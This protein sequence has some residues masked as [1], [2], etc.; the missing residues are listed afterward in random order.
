[1]STRISN[2]GI[3][4]LLLLACLGFT[5]PTQAFINPP[6]A[7][8]TPGPTDTPVPT[9]TPTTHTPTPTGTATPTATLSP[10]KTS[11][12]TF[13]RTFTRTRT[14]TPTPTATIEVEIEKVWSY[15]LES[16]SNEDSAA[17]YWPGGT[18]QTGVHGGQPVWFNVMATRNRV[19]DIAYVKAKLRI[20]PSNHPDKDRLEVRLVKYNDPEE[21]QQFVPVGNGTILAGDTALLSYA[22]PPSCYS[23]YP[24]DPCKLY[25]VVVYIDDDD[26]GYLE[27]EEIVSACMARLK[28][29]SVE[30]YDHGLPVLTELLVFFGQLLYDT[31]HDLIWYFRD[32]TQPDEVS[33]TNDIWIRADDPDLEH[34]VGIDFGSN[35][36][37]PSVEFVFIYTSSICDDI[38]NAY[39][40]Y[41]LVY[42]FLSSKESDVKT[43]FDFYTTIDEF[44][45]VWPLDVGGPTV[46]DAIHFDPDAHWSDPA[47]SIGAA[48]INWLLIVD[49]VRDEQDPTNAHTESV[50]IDGTLTD[51]YDFV[52]NKNPQELQVQSGYP[53]LG[54]SGKVFKTRFDMFNECRAPSHVW[55]W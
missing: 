44:L 13:T 1:M 28:I 4:I 43:F 30:S 26:D 12:R 48:R 10:T 3:I 45:F 49:A 29:N 31:A 2:N 6:V 27:E 52:Y 25:T 14:R 34:R 50:I 20:E 54:T 41:D 5:T 55:N 36:Q 16:N 17:N 47:F 39:E 18:G 9:P 51:V 11:T 33:Q 15:Q 22:H 19:N 35:Q 38:A 21:S 53:T 42:R 40:T 8:D 37:G 7:T 24:V 32:Q 46:V 23:S